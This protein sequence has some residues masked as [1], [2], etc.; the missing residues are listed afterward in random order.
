MPGNASLEAGRYYAH[1]RNR[2]WPIMAELLG[3]GGSYK[4]RLDG[5]RQAGIALWDVL[6]RCER[7]GS[8][9]SA[10]RDEVANDFGRFL[11]EHR[12]IEAVFFNGGTA[13]ALWRKHVA[14]HQSI[15]PVA[16]TA[17]LPSTSPAHAAMSQ[18]DKLKAWRAVLG[19]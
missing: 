6:E 16:R 2:F 5:L 12:S 8:L 4:E 19:P 10:I 13:A 11:N 14:R 18:A 7:P 3:I 1:P 9:D 15:R 17:V